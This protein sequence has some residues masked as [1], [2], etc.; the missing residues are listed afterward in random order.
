MIDRQT[1]YMF[2]FMLLLVFIL[3]AQPQEQLRLLAG[4]GFSLLVVGGVFILGFLS[5]DAIVPA[6]IIGAVAFGFGGLG[7]LSVL[8][9]FFV[10]SSLLTLLNDRRSLNGRVYQ[11][12]RNGKQAWS[13]AWWFALFLVL[14]YV[15]GAKEFVIAAV[16]ALATATSDT[17]AT[18]VGLFPR[19]HKTVSIATFKEVEPGTDG[20]V[21]LYG[22]ISA[23]LGSSLIAAV[24]MLFSYED[25]LL[26]F[27]IIAA[28]G[29]LGCLIDSILGATLQKNEVD[30]P[31]ERLLGGEHAFGNNK[32][33]WLSTGLGGTI[34][35]LAYYFIV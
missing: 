16:S 30:L 35:M 20:G 2:A 17:W 3:V 15:T 34:A 33:N 29:F 32:V 8:G 1:N 22:T 19:R 7:S 18:E 28:S 10:S 26:V 23:L 14:A 12:R 25:Q 9:V 11:S 6:T 24:F 21:S 27:V 5:L 4:I 31:F 13:N